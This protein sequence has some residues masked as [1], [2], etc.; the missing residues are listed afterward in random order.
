M[1]CF[2][3]HVATVIVDVVTSLLQGSLL[4]VFDLFQRDFG[5][6]CFKQTIILLFTLP[7]KKLGWA[8]PQEDESKTQT[9]PIHYNIG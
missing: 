7:Y 4:C 5:T 2:H 6:T 8:L 9:S 3:V 1:T